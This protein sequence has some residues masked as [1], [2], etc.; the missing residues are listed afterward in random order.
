VSVRN[1]RKKFNMAR[2]ALHYQKEIVPALRRDLG[3]K[4]V[5]QVPR[6]QKVVVNVGIGKRTKEA[7][8]LKK[9]SELLERITGQKPSPRPSRIS[10]AG[11]K[12]R[13]GMVVGVRVTIRGPRMYD[14]LERL[15]TMVFPRIRDFRGISVKGFDGRGN[16]SWGMTEV[17]AFPEATPE[18]IELGQPLEITV[19][20]NACTNVAGERLLRA[21]GFPFNDTLIK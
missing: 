14:F 7:D 1:V 3:L 19:V 16:Y 6:I 18:D 2:L 13:E 17:N 4:N 5:M 12:M 20:T 21:L 15:T 10:I 9:V 8:H 11:F